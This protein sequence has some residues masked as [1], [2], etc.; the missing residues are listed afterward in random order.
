MPSKAL[1]RPAQVVAGAGAVVVATGTWA[2]IPGVL[3]GA[4]PWCS[5]DSG[6][7]DSPGSVLA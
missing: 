3:A 7:L 1:L 4:H 5:P 6:D 2:V